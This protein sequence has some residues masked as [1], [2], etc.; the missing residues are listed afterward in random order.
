MHANRDLTRTKKKIVVDHYRRLVGSQG[1]G[2]RNCPRDVSYATRTS[3][4]R[5]NE[6][7]SWHSTESDTRWFISI[8]IIIIIIMQIIIERSTRFGEIVI[9]DTT[10]YR[11]SSNETC[12]NLNK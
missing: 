12:D 10:Q 2:E 8:R 7:L 9:Q 1:C 11:A 5:V 3:P 4:T 6:A